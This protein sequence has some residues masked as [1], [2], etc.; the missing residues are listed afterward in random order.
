MPT[1]S[2]KRRHKLDPKHAKAAA[3]K[4]AKDLNK[5]YGLIC[6]WNGDEATFDGVGV[7]GTM[8]VGKSQI[9]LDVQLSLLLAA[10]K[11]PIERAINKEL[12]AVLNKA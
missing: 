9:E 10:L 4:V 7:S 8:V 6:Q 1:I 11:G 2:I 12:E 3:Q 5:R